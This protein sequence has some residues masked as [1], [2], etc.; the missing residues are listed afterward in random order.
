MYHTKNQNRVRN[1]NEKRKGALTTTPVQLETKQFYRLESE[2]YFKDPLCPYLAP[3]SD[4]KNF[5][6]I[7]CISALRLIELHHAKKCVL[8]HFRPGKTQTGL[9]SY[10]D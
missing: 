3:L 1:L 7:V 5:R 9:L 6:T 10:S 4:F 8:E 2:M